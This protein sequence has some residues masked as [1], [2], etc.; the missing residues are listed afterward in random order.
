MREDVIDGPSM[1]KALMAGARSL[2]DKAA[3]LNRINVFPV[4]DGDT[5]TNMACT[6]EVVITNIPEP[7]PSEVGKVLDIAARSMLGSSRGNS[8]A[9]LAQFMLGLAAELRGETAVTAMR[10]SRAAVSAAQKAK[11]ALREPKEGTILTVLEDWAR[12]FHQK[13]QDT[14][15]FLTSFLHAGNVA[16]ASC[17]R[18]IA[19]LPE[20]RKAHVVDAG[21]KGFVHIIEGIEQFLRTGKFSRELGAGT[22]VASSA[23]LHLGGPVGQFRYCTEAL[24]AK[25]TIGLDALR[26]AA[27]E[28]GDSIVVA[29]DASLCRIHIH[30]SRPGEFFDYL[31]TLGEAS[32]HKVDDMLLQERI[33]ARAMRRCAIVA[34]SACDLPEGELLKYGIVRVPLILFTNG[35]A[36]SDGAGFDL[37][38]LHARMANDP[39][40]TISTSQ[41]THAAFERS[42]SIALSTAEQVLYIG[43]ASVL[44]GTFEAGRRAAERFGNL[45]RCVDG[46]EITAGYGLLVRKAAELAERGADAETIVEAIEIWRKKLLLYVAVP[47]LTSLI[48]TGRLSGVKGLVLTKLGIRPIIAPSDEGRAVSGGMYVGEKNGV[49]KLLSNIKK[50]VRR[51]V[52]ASILISHV[53]A[54]GEAARLREAVLGYLRPVSRVD[55][56]QMGPLLAS[57]AWLGAVGIAV[58][59]EE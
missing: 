52:R 45:V 29:G 59:P 40:L 35:R 10:F 56:V 19:I 2:L 43:F 9:I 13:A 23:A 58:L 47:N 17:A 25:P 7:L 44:S 26:D 1:G 49:R 4:P 32:G 55:I 12:A 15:N 31:D 5:G 27:G 33:V 37:A 22:A 46:R 39:A 36:R 8:G 18:T 11:H 16:R 38:R 21:A 51:G 53:N 20:M 3:Q 54:P 57:L 42:F 24:L 50:K 14:Q 30:T 28:F 41:P 34:D 6:M 48:R